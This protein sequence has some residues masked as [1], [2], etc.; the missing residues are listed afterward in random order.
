MPRSPE[1]LDSRRGKLEAIQP[2]PRVPGNRNP[3]MGYRSPCVTGCGYRSPRRATTGR[4]APRRTCTPPAQTDAEQKGRRSEGYFGRFEMPLRCKN[5]RV[6]TLDA[7]RLRNARV[8]T[9]LE[10]RLRLRAVRCRAAYRNE[11]G[12]AN[13]CATR[14]TWASTPTIRARRPGT[15]TGG[16][17][18]KARPGGEDTL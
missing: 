8:W 1:T 11:A 9:L 17:K 2:N 3:S 10:N 13:E 7:L 6:E 12:N 18:G 5:A 14:R 15:A 16:R 4:P